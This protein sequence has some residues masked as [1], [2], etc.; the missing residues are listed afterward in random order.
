[1]N[2]TNPKMVMLGLDKTKGT[3]S[4]IIT[5][6][7]NADNFQK[8][9]LFMRDANYT[10]VAVTFTGSGAGEPMLTGDMKKSLKFD[11]WSL[12]IH[13][14]AHF[15]YSDDDGN[16]FQKNSDDQ[17]KTWVLH[18]DQQVEILK[19]SSED[20]VDNDFSDSVLLIVGYKD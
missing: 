11:S 4:G 6:T 12:P 9:E 10:E 18:E 13:M 1:M 19:V 14:V 17:I 15:S 5:C 3:T 20:G 16:S 7:A 8:V 2:E